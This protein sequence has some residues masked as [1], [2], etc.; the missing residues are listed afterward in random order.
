MMR[1]LLVIAY[2]FPPQ[3]GSGTLRVAK[4][5]KYLPEFGWE[6]MVVA[7]SLVTQSDKGLLADLPATLQPSRT[8]EL[9]LILQRLKMSRPSSGKHE[10]TGPDPSAEECRTRRSSL[11][12][13]LQA[14]GQARLNRYLVPDANVLAWAPFAYWRARHLIEANRVDA[15]FSTSP[16]HSSQLVGYWLKRRY[17]RLPWIMDLRDLWSQ[18]HLIVGT[19]SYRRCYSQEERCLNAADRI[20]VVTDGIRRLTL[21]KFPKLHESKIATLTNGYDP[22]DLDTSFAPNRTGRF[23]VTFIGSWYEA[24]NENALLPALLTLGANPHV[25]SRIQF[26][27]VG[28]IP[29]AIRN[30][31]APLLATGSAVIRPPVSQR[32]ALAEVLAADAVL[33]IESNLFELKLNHSNK[34]FEYLG[35]GKPILAVIPSDGEAAKV[36]QTENAGIIV[37]PDN[38]LKIQEAILNQIERFERGQLPSSSPGGYPHYHRRNLT[39]VLADVLNSCVGERRG[40]SNA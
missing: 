32:D 13:K 37:D 31:L 9:R 22:A 27:F 15:I 34:L 24:R 40:D 4:H 3:G 19:P 29:P 2:H 25:A 12:G 16:P 6:P 21:G 30:R 11:F 1:K 35:S 8:N 5:C 23:V 18:S 17:P 33:L 36:I 7:T 20:L 38:A 28:H 39:R 26:R 14:L 10:T